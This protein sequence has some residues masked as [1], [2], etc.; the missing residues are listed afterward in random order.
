M[1]SKGDIVNIKAYVFTSYGR[2]VDEGKIRDFG[3][4]IHQPKGSGL[5]KALFRFSFSHPWVGIVLGKSYRATGRY[6]S[7]QYDDTL[8]YLIE[9]KRHSVIMVQPLDGTQRYYEPIPC[10]EEDLEAV[11][12]I[13]E[14]LSTKDK[15]TVLEAHISGRLEELER[16][17]QVGDH[18]AFW[19]AHDLE[20]ILDIVKR[21]EA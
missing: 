2:S 7:V 17:I 20:A 11:L 8:P 3:T 6:H 12:D 18:G 14:A 21:S 16:G 1:V 15:L 13:Q 19:T 9:D 5:I 10:L 4:N